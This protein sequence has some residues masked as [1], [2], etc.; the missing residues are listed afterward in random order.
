M[1]KKCIYCSTSVDPTAVVD[2]CKTCMYKVWG[3]KMSNA[4]IA[5]MEHEKEKGNLDL[6]QVG[7]EVS[8]EQEDGVFHERPSFGSSEVGSVVPHVEE[9]EFYSEA[10]SLI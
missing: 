9:E 5:N 2:M 3:E 8:V 10:N 6:G 1:V 7:S 4:I